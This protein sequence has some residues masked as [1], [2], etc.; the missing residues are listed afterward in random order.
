MIPLMGVDRA[1]RKPS[2]KDLPFQ[3]LLRTFVIQEKRSILNTSRTLE[4]VNPNPHGWH[5]GFRT[6]VEESLQER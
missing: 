6:S 3:M 2:R 4:R 1:K 5:E